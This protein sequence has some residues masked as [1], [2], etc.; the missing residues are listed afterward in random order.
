M[1]LTFSRPLMGSLMLSGL[2]QQGGPF[3][4]LKSTLATRLGDH[5]L[6]DLARNHPDALVF[7]SHQA[8]HSF[9]HL[10]SDHLHP[11]IT[12]VE[13]MDDFTIFASSLPFPHTLAFCRAFSGPLR[14]A[15]FLAQVP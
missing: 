7:S 8:R 14:L 10:S 15:H 11:P 5:W 13:A 3:S 2:T 6:N 4:P 9:P 12:M 1:Y